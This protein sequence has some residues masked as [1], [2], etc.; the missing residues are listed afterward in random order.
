MTGTY[1]IGGQT[2]RIVS[3]YEEVHRLCRDYRADGEP[4]FTVET[5]QTDLDYERTRA[6]YDWPDAYLET[7]AVYRRIAEEMPERDTILMHGSAVALD[8]Q[9]Y[10][11]TAKSGTGKSTH[12]KLWLDVFGERAVIVNDDKPLVRIADGGATVY[13]TPWNGKHRRGQN[14]AVPLKAVCILQRAKENHIERITVSQAY[15]MLVQQTYRPADPLR[16]AGTMALI[17][18]LAA[19]TELYRLGCNMEREAA[20]VACR[21]MK[22]T[23]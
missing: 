22:G 17:D 10:L 15:P 13:G 14:I 3:L 4:D 20:V 1:R 2:I 8:G 23:P 21:G 12:A 19:G 11:F 18:R 9:A 16:L 6:E 5:S 7:L